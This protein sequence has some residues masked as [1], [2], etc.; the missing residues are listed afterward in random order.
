MVAVCSVEITAT[1]SYIYMHI[2]SKNIM[3]YL[4]H[5]TC[6]INQYCLT[7]VIKRHHCAGLTRSNGH[8]DNVLMT[9]SWLKTSITNLR[10]PTQL[11]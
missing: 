3:K 2:Y 11:A 1:H 4:Q 8:S 9:Q 7:E 6:Q 10:W 5:A